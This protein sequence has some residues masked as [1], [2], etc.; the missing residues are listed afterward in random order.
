MKLKGSH[1]AVDY[2]ARWDF[3][4]RTFSGIEQ[5]FPARFCKG[6]RFELGG[7][8]DV[9]RTKVSRLGTPVCTIHE[10]HAALPEGLF[11]DVVG[12][13]TGRV[14]RGAYWPY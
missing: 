1:V 3:G 9:Q 2:R 11:V 10:A 14:V 13:A 7:R 8:E 12:H 5:G 6:Q 4:C